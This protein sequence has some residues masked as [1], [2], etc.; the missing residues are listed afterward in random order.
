MSMHA[1]SLMLTVGIAS[2]LALLAMSDLRAAQPV[3]DVVVY[4]GTSAGVATAVQARRA[5]K[6]VVL[7]GPDIHLGGLSSGGLDKT[8][9][10]NH[11]VIG[12][13]SREIFESP[14]KKP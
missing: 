5:G 3:Y 10:G 12:G 13:M 1:R 11:S 4:G 2:V 8:D 6:T 9:T 14:G 7:V